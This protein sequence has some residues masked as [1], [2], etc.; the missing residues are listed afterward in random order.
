LTEA[1]PSPSLN[2]AVQEHRGLSR[3][4]AQALFR[5]GHG[6]AQVDDADLLLIDI[7]PPALADRYQLPVFTHR[8][9]IDH[10]KSIGAKVVMYPHG[11]HPAV[12]YDGLF[13]PYAC[14]DARLVHA[15]GYAEFLRRVEC[16]G[17][18]HVVGWS[19][20]DLMR[21]QARRDV[22][23]VLFAP[24]HPGGSGDTGVEAYREANAAIYER[25]LATEWQLTVRT[26]GTPELNGLWRAEGVEFVPGGMDMGLDQIHAVDAVVAGAGTFPA[27]AIA[28][29]VPTVI[30]AHGD[31]AMYGLPDEQPTPLLRP[32]RYADYVRY[33]FTPD[34]GP[35]DEVVHAAAQSEEPIA[36]WK[37]R[38]IG[39]PFDEAAAVAIVE[40]IVWDHPEPRMLD[41][42]RFTVVAFVDE[43]LERPELLTRYAECF[44]REHDATL[45]L[46]GPGL[47][48]GAVSAAA[49]DAVRTAGLDEPRLPHLVAFAHPHT[50]EADRFLAERADALLSEWPPVGRIAELP[51]YGAVEVEGLR[52]RAAASSPS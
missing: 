33:P 35:L 49:R 12:E 17:E 25:L 39:E 20:C 19:L 41:S 45:A 15:V 5:A 42:R 11:V 31:P 16:R 6:A 21:F 10:Y 48:Q 47:D 2:I 30:Y 13:E 36:T 26:V 14:V 1:P 52:A 7:D 28:R 3:P 27:L 38:F 4:F 24:I 18:V 23:R 9:V 51:R 40:R 29:G 37:R 8:L 43:V 50:L 32:D 44:A 22:R 34:D 46:W